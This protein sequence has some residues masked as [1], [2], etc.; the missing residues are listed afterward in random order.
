MTN[1]EIIPEAPRAIIR[2]SA[3]TARPASAEQAL[4]MLKLM[5]AEIISTMAGLDADMTSRWSLD[6]DDAAR[7][8][9][10]AQAARGN[11]SRA[12]QEY[13][14]RYGKLDVPLQSLGSDIGAMRGALRPIV[15]KAAEGTERK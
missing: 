6:Q 3:A 11:L 13:A 8:D 9:A 7:C 14:K 5:M 2:Q 4:D 15:E 1:P 12:M 10:K